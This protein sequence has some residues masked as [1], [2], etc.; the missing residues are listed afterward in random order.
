MMALSTADR[1]KLS[2]PARRINE[3]RSP[4]TMQLGGIDIGKRSPQS[5]PKTAIILGSS[6]LQPANRSSSAALSRLEP[7][8]PRNGSGSGVKLPCGG[9]QP[10]H[11]K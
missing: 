9:T 2:H 6:A 7:I 11:S 1:E 4:K 8:C 10:G 5:Q 3:K